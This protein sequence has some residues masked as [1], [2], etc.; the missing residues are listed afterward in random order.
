MSGNKERER[1]LLYIKCR[2]DGSDRAKYWKAEDED[3]VII[4]F[5][6]SLEYSTHYAVPLINFRLETRHYLADELQERIHHF[7]CSF[8]DRIVYIDTITGLKLLQYMRK[9]RGV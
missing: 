3:N 6:N 8:C 1:I 5:V 9:H 4:S 2:C 7:R